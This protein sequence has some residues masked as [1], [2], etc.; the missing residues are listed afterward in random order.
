[1]RSRRTRREQ[2]LKWFA[3]YHWFEHYRCCDQEYEIEDDT[4]T[5]EEFQELKEWLTEPEVDRS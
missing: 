3:R 2:T 5:E 4:W 1:M